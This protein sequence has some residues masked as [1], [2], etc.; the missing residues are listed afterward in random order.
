MDEDDRLFR[1]LQARR[2]AALLPQLAPNQPLPGITT[3]NSNSLNGE[4]QRTFSSRSHKIEKFNGSDF[5]QWKYKLSLIL[6]EEELIDLVRG[7]IQ[8]PI[9]SSIDRKRDIRA[10]S[11][12]SQALDNSQI[13]HISSAT[14]AWEM[15]NRL[16]T[17]HERK[18]LA[19]STYLRK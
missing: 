18:G 1:E 2:Q 12:I 9:L 6:E 11:I 13:P 14:T 4:L 16:S 3:T 17:Q 10:R 15:F 7:E 5:Q 19:S 8:P